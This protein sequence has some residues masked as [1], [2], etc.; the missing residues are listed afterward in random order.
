MT[1]VTKKREDSPQLQDW[2]N[3]HQPNNDLLWHKGFEHQFLFVRDDL[4][5]LF[6]VTFEDWKANPVRVVGTH[7]SKSVLLPVYSL[8]F[9]GIEVRLRYNFYNWKLSIKSNRPVP[10]NFFQLIDRE[11]RISPIY[12]EGFPRNWCFGPYC[13]NPKRF[14]A[15]IGK[16]YDLYTFLYLV[17]EGLNLRPPDAMSRN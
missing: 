6:S 17:S 14:S 16:D 7:R 2:A 12:F 5:R 15:E 13:K 10:D 9:G 11:E 1:S 3:E 8:A 4:S